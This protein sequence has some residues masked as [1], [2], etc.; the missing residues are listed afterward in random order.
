MVR[1][2][3]VRANQLIVP[4]SNPNIYW[5]RCCKIPRN[6]ST[7]IFVWWPLVTRTRHFGSDLPQQ[8]SDQS[9]ARVVKIKHKLKMRDAAK[10]WTR[11]NGQNYKRWPAIGAMSAVPWRASVKTRAALI[12]IQNRES[13]YIYIGSRIYRV[14]NICMHLRLLLQTDTSICLVRARGG[15]ATTLRRAYSVCTVCIELIDYKDPAQRRRT[16]ARI[17]YVTN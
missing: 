12:C 6:K 1:M 10:R 9:I 5:P 14:S 17:H 15:I 13:L 4:A 8:H 7:R 11:A 2:V 3:N 16:C